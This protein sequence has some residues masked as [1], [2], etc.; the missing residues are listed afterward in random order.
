SR[1]PAS[2]VNEAPRRFSGRGFA[3]PTPVPRAPRPEAAA[4]SPWYESR[5]MSDVS[6]ALP[7]LSDLD[8]DNRRVFV[9]VDFNV[10][11]DKAGRITDDTRIVAALPTISALQERGA[12]LVLASHLGRPK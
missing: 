3:D 4:A 12:R 2:P 10:P 8:V 11:L 1:G 7:T 9:R 5:P 6:P